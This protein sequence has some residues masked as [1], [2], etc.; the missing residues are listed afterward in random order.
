MVNGKKIGVGSVWLRGSMEERGVRGSGERGWG[1]GGGL[2]LN[3]FF[4]YY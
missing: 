2:A 3:R 1:R 4:L